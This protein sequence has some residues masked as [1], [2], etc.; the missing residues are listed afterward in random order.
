MVSVTARRG[1]GHEA[2]LPIEQLRRAGERLPG[3]DDSLLDRLFALEC[4]TRGGSPAR[5][6][7][8]V[9]ASARRDA[10][11]YLRDDWEADVPHLAVLGQA[12]AA[13]DAADEDA[14]RQWE[15]SLADGVDEVVGR[16]TRFG[17]TSDP[18]LL[19]AVVRG[20]AVTGGTL[21][22]KVLDAAN[23]YL[24]DR[25]TPAGAAEVAE[26]LSRHRGGLE[27]ARTGARAAYEA[28]ADEA[29]VV[30]RYWLA[31]RWRSLHGEELPVGA[32][33]LARVRTQILAAPTPNGSRL[34][35][36]LA[37]VAA[38]SINSLIVMSA[39]SLGRIRAGLR[40]RT[41]AEMYLW[42]VIAIGVACYL[43]LAN[44]ETIIGNV[45][46]WLGAEKPPSTDIV[47]AFAGAVVYVAATL[48]VLAIDAA[49]RRSGRTVPPAISK[50]E[51][52]IGGVAG[53]IAAAIYS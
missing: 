14:P 3:R 22:V 8:T 31:E 6:A 2:E 4:V 5:L 29:A 43:T 13:V 51:W 49:Y 17:L 42:R 52:I 37:E 48:I 10:E 26:A 19:A 16:Q 27:I 9:L 47:R 32:K 38:R 30:A 25:P 50:L 40:T 23:E 15:E 28:P 46:K 34:A 11:R 36:M 45:W 39:E 53:F 24:G 44:L 1:R 12:L 7:A 41:F 18:I 20:L 35:A 33:A 21:P